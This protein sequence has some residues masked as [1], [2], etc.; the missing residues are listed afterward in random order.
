LKGAL[1]S[2]GAQASSAAAARLEQCGEQALDE[3]TAAIDALDRE[4]Q[5]LAPELDAFVSGA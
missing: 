3:I 4:M 2:V 5:R 1:S